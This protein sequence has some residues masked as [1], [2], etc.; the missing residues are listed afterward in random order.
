MGVEIWKNFLRRA[1]GPVKLGRYNFSP[2][3]T[4][5]T[6]VAQLHAPKISHQTD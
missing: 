1:G 2:Y 3:Q 5:R 4:D 6:D